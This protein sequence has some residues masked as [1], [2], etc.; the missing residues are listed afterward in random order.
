MLRPKAREI[1]IEKRKIFLAGSSFSP[2]PKTNAQY[3]MLI[4]PISIEANVRRRH[5]AAKIHK[6]EIE[7]FITGITNILSISPPLAIIFYTTCAF[8]CQTHG[9]KSK[10]TYWPFLIEYILSLPHPYQRLFKK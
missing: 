1:P 10:T 7:I 8:I 3:P 9:R 4:I 5:N 6:A 2:V